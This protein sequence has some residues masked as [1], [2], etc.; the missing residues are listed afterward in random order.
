MDLVVF[1][2]FFSFSFK[3]FGNQM[4]KKYKGKMKL[5]LANEMGRFHPWH[6]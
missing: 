3:Q 5:P 6:I 2:F 4:V 1:F